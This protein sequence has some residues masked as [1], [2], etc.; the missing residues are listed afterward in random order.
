MSQEQSTTDIWS[1]ISAC[2]RQ[3]LVEGAVIAS[4]VRGIGFCATCSLAVFSHS[5]SKPVS[6]NGP[7]FNKTDQNVILWL[8]HR[9]VAEAD[10]I[11][12]THDSLLK[13]V[14]GKMS[15]EMEIPKILWLKNHMPK[16]VFGSCK[17][18][19]LTDA[20]TFL[21]TGNETRSFCSAVC[22]QG[23]VPIGVDGSEKGW[24]DEFFEAIGLEDFIKDNYIRL[25]GVDGVVSFFGR[26]C[27][28]SANSFTEWQISQCWRIGRPSQ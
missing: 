6:V 21:A 5:T 18:Y 16:D 11:N 27:L 24:K 3:V 23:F 26:E 17:F 2:V 28:N 15:V 19:D 12:G 14:G 9:P 10:K 4:S 22:K 13:Y 25:G 20:L 7:D 1:C 8:D